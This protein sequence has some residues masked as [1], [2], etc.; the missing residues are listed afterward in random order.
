MKGGGEMLE[1]RNSDDR[2]VCCLDETSGTVEI[3]VKDCTTLLKRNPDGTMMII[4][5]KNSAS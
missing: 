3:R 2:L 5:N 4:N 1:V